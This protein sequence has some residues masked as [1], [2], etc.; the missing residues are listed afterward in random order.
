MF[1]DVIDATLMAPETDDF[2]AAFDLSGVEV[3]RLGLAEK[4]KTAKDLCGYELHM[5]PGLALR[6]S[7]VDVPEYEHS[8]IALVPINVAPASAMIEPP[9]PMPQP[10]PALPAT[11]EDQSD[12]E[13]DS[14]LA[15]AERSVSKSTKSKR[16]EYKARHWR[17]LEKNVLIPSEKLWVRTWKDFI[18]SER[19]AQLNYFDAEARRRRMKSVTTKQEQVDIAVIVE[20]FIRDIEDV[21]RSLALK[22]RSTVSKVSEFAYDFT[23]ANDLGGIATLPLDSESIVTFLTEYEKRLV[24]TVPR[25]IQNNLRK[26]LTQGFSSGENLAQLRS[27]VAQVFDLSSTSSKTIQIARTESGA[28]VNGVR[29][30]MFKEQG[31]DE[32]EWS[33][34]QDEFVRESHVVYGSS[35]NHPEGFNY[36]SLTTG[37]GI[38]EYPHDPRAPAHETINCRCTL[39]PI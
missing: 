14:A 30:Q 22:A 3:L 27:R 11:D 26:T 32:F 7:G 12:E 19:S 18:A 1:E 21:K 28:I 5:P 4:V 17:A 23:A 8:G 35:G 15:D 24:G 6:I 38:L 37:D 33:T 25:T 10:A 9:E 2:V 16:S 20:A 13:D 34:A 31:F 39:L 29:R 36:L